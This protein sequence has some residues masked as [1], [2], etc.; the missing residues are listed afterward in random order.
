[1]CEKGLPKAEIDALRGRLNG[2]RDEGEKITLKLVKLQDLWKECCRDGKA[3]HRCSYKFLQ[4]SITMSP[5]LIFLKRNQQIFFQSVKDRDSPLGVISMN[6][7]NVRYCTYDL[8]RGEWPTTAIDCFV[9][10]YFTPPCK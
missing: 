9:F 8:F 7:I 4:Y 6:C 2:L 3:L 10:P 5:F 1:M